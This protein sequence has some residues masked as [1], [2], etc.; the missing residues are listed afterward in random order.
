MAIE[1]TVPL[2]GLPEQGTRVHGRFRPL[3]DRASP[4]ARDDGHSATRR[5]ARSSSMPSTAPSR[6]S[7]TG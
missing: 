2:P 6:T 4:A 5:A 7:P 1:G 3:A